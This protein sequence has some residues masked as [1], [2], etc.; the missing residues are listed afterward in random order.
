MNTPVL[1]LVF[2]RIEL[3]QQVFESIRKSRP[4]RLYIASDGARLS[5]IG[6]IDKVAYIRDYLQ[7]NIDWN[8]EVKTLFR[9]SNL[10]CKVAVSEA[11]NWFFENEQEG[12]IVEDDC[13]PSQSF[14]DFCEDMLEKYRDD[15]R[16]WHISGN[17]FQKQ[18]QHND[19]EYYFS[20]IP[21]IWG[22][23]TWSNRWD[24]Y[25][26]EMKAFNSLPGKIAVDDFFVDKKQVNYW[27]ELL[28]SSCVN[29]VDAWDFQWAYAC[30]INNGLSIN[31]NRN[32]VTNIGFGQEATHTKFENT[33]VS[34][35]K[36]FDIQFPVDKVNI[37]TPSILAD[38]YSMKRLFYKRNIIIRVINKISRIILNKEV[39]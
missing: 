23:A 14:F 26:V 22:W 25:D 2:N 4:P 5:K 20:K 35:L 34:N 27:L 39:I 21:H 17:N 29:K 7:N 12:I 9:E 15:L 37:T 32:M 30:F 16:V 36:S 1:F 38:T 33:R 10:G 13:L 6:E 11:I 19:N 24:S 8:C 31:P 18:K 3:T 28:E